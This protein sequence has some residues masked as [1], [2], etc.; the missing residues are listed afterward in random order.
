M[1]GAVLCRAAFDN[2]REKLAAAAAVAMPTVLTAYPAFAA[3][4]SAEQRTPWKT[5][6]FRNVKSGSIVVIF[7]LSEILVQQVLCRLSICC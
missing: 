5:F 6:F 4:V 2:P 7:V 3:D 1:A